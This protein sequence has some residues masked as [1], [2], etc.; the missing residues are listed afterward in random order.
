[1][2]A[3]DPPGNVSYFIAAEDA[4]LRCPAQRSLANASEKK[5]ESVRH[6]GQR[7]SETPA[8]CGSGG[9]AASTPTCENNAG[10]CFAANAGGPQT[11]IAVAR[12]VG[13]T[14]RDCTAAQKRTV[15]DV[16]NEIGGIDPPVDWDR[17]GKLLD[18]LI[19]IGPSMKVWSRLLCLVRPDLYCTVAVVIEHWPV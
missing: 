15:V 4:M 8:R 5:L 18:R 3:R 12:G 1:L 10:K 14:G 19:S 7:F 11:R 6:S 17:L 13:G 2:E 9:L 16:I